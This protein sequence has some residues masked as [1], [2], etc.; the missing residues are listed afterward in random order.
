MTEEYLVVALHS[1]APETKNRLKFQ[2]GEILRVFS[3]L[4][5]GWMDGEIVNEEDEGLSERGNF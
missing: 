5:S 2:T 3:V 1:Y 4:E